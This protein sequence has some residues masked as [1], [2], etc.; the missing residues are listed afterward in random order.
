VARACPDTGGTKNAVGDEGDGADAGDTDTNDADQIRMLEIA[1]NLAAK[2]R[3]GDMERDAALKSV[4]E[5]ASANKVSSRAVQYL[6]E[7]LP[8]K[9][10][11]ALVTAL[12]GHVR[13][14]IN[15][16]YANYVVQ[17]VV[18]LMTPA[19]ASFIIEELLGNAGAVAR[20]RFGCRVLCR[21]LEHCSMGNE[22]VTALVDEILSDTPAL[23]RHTFGNYVM[24]HVLEFGAPEQR[25]IIA[26]ALL[27]DVR[28]AKNRNASHVLEKALEVCLPDDQ[29]ALAE[30]LLSSP[31]PL[32]LLTL[33]EHQFGCFVVRALL[34]LPGHFA[35]ETRAC[36][37]PHV[38]KLEASR[39]GRKVLEEFRLLEGE[40]PNGAEC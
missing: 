16:P 31:H 37:E 5:V 18:E 33:A 9:D 12:H 19:Q 23:C 39:H 11:V 35:Q 21:V 4:P 20:H 8:M 25:H 7:K 15:S 2:L 17:K 1:D 6:L 3:A 13:N 10:Q 40:S 28:S 36:L 34:R 38:S 32:D 29:R 14:A 24:Q 26:T 30:H 27:R 22:H